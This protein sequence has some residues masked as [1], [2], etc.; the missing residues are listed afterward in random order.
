MRSIKQLISAFEKYKKSISP[1]NFEDKAVAN[2]LMAEFIKYKD[3]KEVNK[4]IYK[5]INEK[6]KI[7]YGNKIEF[8]NLIVE[9]W[10]D[11]YNNIVND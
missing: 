9:C 8:F 4:Y 7:V 2:M 10:A 3:I 6:V 1:Y 5:I 11:V